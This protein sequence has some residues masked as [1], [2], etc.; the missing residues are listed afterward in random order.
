MAV[1]AVPGLALGAE[2]P[3][4]NS[5]KL[6]H[7]ATPAP[8]PKAT[9]AAVPTPPSATPELIEK[10]RQLDARRAP[11]KDL[12]A[13]LAVTL[14]K[15][16]RNYALKGM[17]SGN[18]AGDFRLSMR[19]GILSIIDVAFKGDQ[20]DLWLPRKGKHCLGPRKTVREITNDLRLL[21]RIGSVS[22]LFFPDAWA[23]NAIA[24]RLDEVDG[25][26]FL[27]VLEQR[28]GELLP[29]RRVQ[30]SSY[31]DKCVVAKT[32]LY[33]KGKP[34]GAVEYR[35]YYVL[36]GWLI[37]RTV[38]VWAS[39]KTRIVLTVDGIAINTGRPLDMKVGAPAGV[40]K[41]DLGETLKAGKI[42]E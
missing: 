1:L 32:I 2:V 9:P 38:E 5:T 36:S 19:W 18:A 22:D 35:D 24:R 16:K 37:P 20:V 27:N 15:G 11:L 3:S 12:R 17:Y 8:A 21:E 30:L 34:I 31:G 4:L 40:K 14:K 23:D 33:D 26:R 42:F 41:A 29:T 28:D 13:R 25:H 10:V 7:L 39:T 6:A